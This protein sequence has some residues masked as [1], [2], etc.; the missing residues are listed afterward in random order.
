MNNLKFVTC[1]IINIFLLTIFL[2]L[3]KSYAENEQIVKAQKPISVKILDVTYRAKSASTCKVEFD[4]KMYEN[5]SLPNKVAVGKINQSDFFYNAGVSKNNYDKMLIAWDIAGYNNKNLAY[6]SPLKYCGG[7]ASRTRLISRGWNFIGDVSE[8]IT[9]TSSKTG[10]WEE[11][12]TWDLE[13]IPTSSDNVILSPSHII[14]IITDSAEANKVI[15]SA[16]A[17]LQ[18]TNTLAKLKLNL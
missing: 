6:V 7:Q 5:I 17:A 2:Q 15:I 14:T 13:K 16:N 10:N 11:T 3:F 4:G 1:S 18:F 9:I 8:C 12:T